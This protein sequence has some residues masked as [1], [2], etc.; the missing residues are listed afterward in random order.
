MREIVHIQAGQCG[1]QI[2]AKVSQRHIIIVY[3][4]LPPHSIFS[5]SLYR[6]REISRI[7]GSLA[8]LSVA[9]AFLSLA[10]AK[11][12][13]ASLPLRECV[14]REKTV[15]WSTLARGKFHELLSHIVAKRVVCVFL[16]LSSYIYIHIYSYT[17]TWKKSLSR[18]VTVI[19]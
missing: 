2:G 3:I 7:P 18:G 15:R 4:L 8:R 1:N 6:L 13:A 10:L 19:R 11:A 9:L 12:A 16:S 17:L 14:R 5:L